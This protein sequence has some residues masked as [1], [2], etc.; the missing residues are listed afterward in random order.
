[1]NDRV[2]LFSLS[3]N[4]FRTARITRISVSKFRP[5]S[6]RILG[7]RSHY[8]VSAIELFH[9]L[10]YFRDLIVLL[11]NLYGIQA[12]PSF[13]WHDIKFIEVA[14][15]CGI[16]IL[17]FSNILGFFS[18][19]SN[20]ILDIIVQLL[21]HFSGNASVLATVSKLVC[22]YQALFYEQLVQIFYPQ[23]SQF[24][25][26]NINDSPAKRGRSYNILYFPI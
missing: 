18:I 1:M 17:C 5:M 22:L 25:Y 11:V 24:F 14:P 16:F 12:D 26:S 10:L 13:S 6:L 2:D 3:Y 8:T 19:C 20:H 9:D 21:Q 23:S 15:F 4:T 7:L